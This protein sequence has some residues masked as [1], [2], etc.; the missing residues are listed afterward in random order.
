MVSQIQ[1]HPKYMRDTPYQTSLEGAT[2]RPVPITPYTPIAGEATFLQNEN[3]DPQSRAQ[4]FMESAQSST[5]NFSIDDIFHQKLSLTKDR[6]ELILDEIQDIN[7]VRCSNLS[8][9]Y[10][11]LFMIDQW[12]CQRSFPE[13]YLKDKT[14]MD[15]NKMELQIRDQ[16][17]RE[18]KDAMRAKSFNEKDLREALLDFKKQNQ[19]SQLMGTMWADENIDVNPKGGGETYNMTGDIYGK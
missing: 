13:N 3:S 11:D 14:W 1:Y 18:M 6:T 15:F 10:E 12:R 4:S 9:L 5:D 16:I 19:K 2:I 8:R 7:A 17:R